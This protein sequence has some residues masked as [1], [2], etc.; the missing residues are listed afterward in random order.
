MYA[1]DAA[2]NMHMRT[3]HNEL[4]KTERD[5]KARDIIKTCGLKS[6]TDIVSKLGK[7]TK[8]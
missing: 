1:T 4:T 8:L 3:K 7:L 5:K 6:N 2:R